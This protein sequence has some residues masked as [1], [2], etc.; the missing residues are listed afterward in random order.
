[1]KTK[2]IGAW[3]VIMLFTGLLLGS[4]IKKDNTPIPSPNGKFDG[5]FRMLRKKSVGPGYDTVIKSTIRLTTSPD[6]GFR[7]TGDTTQHAGSR[8]TYD[9]NLYY[10]SFADVTYK[11]TS[12][13][14]H[15]N[16]LYRYY[17]DGE[18]FQIARSYLDTLKLQYE[19]KRAN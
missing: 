18:N 5:E 16:D 11:T 15:L 2:K 9:Y 19:L 17:Y 4:C 7:V 6:S 8:G 10:I 1:M 12:T 3:A 13:K 14:K